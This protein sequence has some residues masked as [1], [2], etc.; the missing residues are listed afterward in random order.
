M[1]K[2]FDQVVRVVMGLAAC[3]AVVLLAIAIYGQLR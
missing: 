1:N 3:G 2:D